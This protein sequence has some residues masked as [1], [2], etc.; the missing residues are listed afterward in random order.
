MR[1]K[2]RILGALLL[3]VKSLW[4]QKVGSR[5]QIYP[6]RSK[7]VLIS[8]QAKDFVKNCLKGRGSMSPF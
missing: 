1:Q 5:G 3:A 4:P 8:D 2:D 6:V 7:L